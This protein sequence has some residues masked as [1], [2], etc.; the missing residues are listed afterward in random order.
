MNNKAFIPLILILKFSVLGMSFSSNYFSVDSIKEIEVGS[1]VL[2]DFKEIESL[3]LS[4]C[5][6]TSV[7]VIKQNKKVIESFRYDFESEEYGDTI[8]IENNREMFSSF[9]LLQLNDTHIKLAPVKFNGEDELKN[10]FCVLFVD[11]K[12]VEGI[13]AYPSPSKINKSILLKIILTMVGII[14]IFAIPITIT[15][16]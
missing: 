8:I 7:A 14:S 6:D 3:K 10:D 5:K 4:V 12:D 1:V 11:I 9:I 15:T 13:N 2:L 16:N